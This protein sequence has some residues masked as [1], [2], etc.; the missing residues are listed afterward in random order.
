[1]RVWSTE[2]TRVS[3]TANFAKI[4]AA[5]NSGGKNRRKKMDN[6]D[7]RGGTLI[8][9]RGAVRIPKAELMTIEPPAATDTWKPVAHGVL[10]NTLTDVLSTRGIAVKREEYAVQRQGHILF[11]VMDLA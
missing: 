5:R 9:H 4:L 6:H 1:M 3:P 11:G 10:V 8:T 2:P 7:K